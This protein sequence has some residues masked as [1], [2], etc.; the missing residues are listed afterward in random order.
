MVADISVTGLWLDRH[1]GWEER[2]QTHSCCK[3]GT[4]DAV[5]RKDRP[6]YRI[7]KKRRAKRATDASSVTARDVVLR[8]SLHE[9]QKNALVGLSLLQ[10]KL[11]PNFDKNQGTQ[12]FTIIRRQP[13][14]GLFAEDFDHRLGFYLNGQTGTGPRRNAEWETVNLPGMAIIDYTKRTVVHVST[15]GLPQDTY[16]RV[17]GRLQYVPDFGK[18]GVLISM[19]GAY[20][21]SPNKGHFLSQK[22]ATF[23]SVDVFDIQSY[24]DNR[25]ENGTWYSQRTSGDIPRSRIDFCSVHK[26]APDGSFQYMYELRDVFPSHK[27]TVDCS[28]IYGGRNPMQ[29]NSR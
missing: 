14:Y 28:Y 20:G 13:D 21:N 9:D 6:E 1:G 29:S 27:L 22:L 17:G 8:T 24:L 12:H 3:R 2:D 25:A 4:Y 23:D 5:R 15:P 7:S 11:S 19:G 10:D 26:S 16:P 18:G